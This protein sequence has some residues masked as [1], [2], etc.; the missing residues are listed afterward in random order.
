VYLPELLSASTSLEQFEPVGKLL[1]LERLGTQVR[2]SDTVDRSGQG[3]A[4][5]DGDDACRRSE[6]CCWTSDR[7]DPPDLPPTSAAAR[8]RILVIDDHPIARLGIRQMIAQEQDLEICGEADSGP[9]AL[10][11]LA[12]TSPHLAI[13]D[14]SL[15]ESSGLELIREIRASHP[16]VLILVLSM[17]D[18]MLYA[19]RVLRAGARGYIMKREAITGL[20]DAIRTV[21]AGRVHVSEAVTQAMLERLGREGTVAD[22]PLSA[23]SDRELEVFD[24]IGR[25]RGL[26]TAAIANQLRV[27]IK[28]IETYRSNIRTKLNLRNASDL[29]RFAASWVEGLS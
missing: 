8:A 24:L 9:V 7:V 28:T 13:V 3:Q 2:R 15:P 25:G 19:E 10:A 29:T 11:M 17:H 21:M 27:S 18:E 20:V 16:N 6:N 23:L 22:N 4:L 12:D 26:T 5:C 1:E 14:L